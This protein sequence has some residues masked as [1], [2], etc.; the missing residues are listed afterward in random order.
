MNVK[1]IRYTPDADELCGRAAAKCYN[2][3]DPMRSLSHAMHGGHLSVAE[4][5]SFTFEIDGLSRVAL[6][7]LTRHRIASFSVESQ[8]YCG[9][10]HRPVVLPDS[11]KKKGY[12]GSLDAALYELEELY[13]SMIK[14]GIPKEDARM[15]LPQGISTSL[16]MTMNAREL[17]HFFALR[18]CNRAQWE[19][20]QLADEMLKECKKAA[21]V[22]FESAGCGCVNGHC[23]EGRRSCGKPRKASE[24]E[25]HSNY[26]CE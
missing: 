4:H 20:R 26:P 5:A 25:E 8:R 15:I 10:T 12:V 16:I 1:L 22:L 23:P 21:P 9:A 13:D 17:L 19:I 6:A 2:G 3:K 24:W 14:D 7:Q 18:T 11:F